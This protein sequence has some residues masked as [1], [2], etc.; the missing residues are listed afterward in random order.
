[1][2]K[3]EDKIPVE[4]LDVILI[5]LNGDGLHISFLVVRVLKDKGQRRFSRRRPY[6]GFASSTS[7]TQ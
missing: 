2:S 3:P 4:N 6:I 5:F 1:M 7:G